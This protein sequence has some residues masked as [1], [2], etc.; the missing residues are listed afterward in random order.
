MIFVS[1]VNAPMPRDR[2]PARSFWLPGAGCSARVT[3][4]GVLVREKGGAQSAY[5]VPLPSDCLAVDE[6]ADCLA[7]ECPH[8]GREDDV[9]L[10]VSTRDGWDYCWCLACREW[11]RR[12]FAEQ[13]EEHL[14]EHC[15]VVLT[16]SREGEC[17]HCEDVRRHR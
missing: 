12:D 7:T 8:C 17:E 15:E 11:H 4:E 14:C 1:A 3:A 6:D 16:L 10:V 9:L 13:V 5:A 2:S